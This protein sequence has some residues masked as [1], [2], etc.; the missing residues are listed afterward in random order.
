MASYRKTQLAKRESVKVILTELEKIQKEFNIDPVTYNRIRGLIRS[1]F[2]RIE[3]EW[4]RLFMEEFDRKRWE[5]KLNLDG[6]KI[7]VHL[8]ERHASG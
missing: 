3:N 5:N 6:E 1:R 7:E 4:I 2:I 8:V